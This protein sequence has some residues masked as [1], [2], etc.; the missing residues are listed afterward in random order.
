MA[1]Q[2]PHCN[3][4][5][6]PSASYCAGCGLQL[7]IPNSQS[8]QPSTV[9]QNRYRIVSLLGQGGFGAVYRAWDNSLKRPCAVKE[10]LETGSQARDQF[11]QEASVLANLSHPN[12]PR[13]IDHFF[14]P[15]QGQYL[16]MDFVEGQ[17]LDALIRQQGPLPAREGIQVISQIA[18]ALNYLHTQP[19]PVIHRD[20]KPANIR[21]RA[22]GRA[23][24]VDFGLVKLLK[25]SK[26]TSAGARGITPGY[27][28]PE[29]YGHGGTDHRT[30]IYALGATLYSL[31]TGLDPQESV[32]RAGRDSIPHAHLVN[33]AIP[34]S[35]GAVIARSMALDPDMRYQS[36]DEFRTALVNALSF[37][38][39]SGTVVIPP[40]PDSILPDQG[41]TAPKS[42]PI[43][44]GMAIGALVMA[45]IIVI[46]VG[47]GW[48]LFGGKST[49][50]SVADEVLITEEQERILE[51]TEAPIV[52]NDAEA[53]DVV[54]EDKDPTITI[55]PS[56]TPTLSPTIT[57]T[58]APQV[59]QPET[60]GEWI[61]YAYGDVR[62]EVDLYRMNMVTGQKQQ[63]TSGHYMDESPT[64]SPD[65]RSLVYVSCR[66]ECEL[67]Q[68]DLH[69][70][71]V[72]QLTNSPVKTKFPNYCND[73][74][75][76]WIVFEGRDGNDKNVWMLDIN[77]GEVKQL[78]HTN[79]DSRPTWSPDCSR[80]VF[81]RA[82]S[83]T[84]RDGQITTYDYLDIYVLD[85]ETLDVSRLTTTAGADEFNFAW[86]SDG[87]W[88]SFCRVS[89][90]TNND[91]FVNLNDRSDLFIV[92]Y[93]GSGERRL[94]INNLSVFYPSWSP[95][96]RS[97]MFSAFTSEGKQSIWSYSLDSGDL[98]KHTEVGPYYHPEWSP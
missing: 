86:S 47:V 66:G 54:S 57:P 24:L 19:S 12:L 84:D 17:D 5:N 89:M 35:V 4:T 77:S 31:L 65:G 9:L 7:A 36:A 43:L 49:P 85:V 88:I 51:T 25:T 52:E 8:L 67:Y 76:P 95:D 48:S 37:P 40:P 82:T 13:V 3:K 79:A 23:F 11:Q 44:S 69:S 10:N 46:I 73:P 63:L 70:L 94:D 30:D 28:P 32:E 22:D 1:Q 96:G 91:S 39:P 50:T 80:I 6:P 42:K 68:L 26:M 75:K 72:K 20:I 87:E 92:R 97:V 41:S 61:A 90:D 59:S 53:E 64:F 58:P 16:V 71:S 78:T 98:T 33:P 29:Q 81:G 15:G 34:S 74:S 56:L 14:L 2:C 45:V 93:D 62:G 27:S 38:I 55:I 21:V 18:D 83:D 60:N